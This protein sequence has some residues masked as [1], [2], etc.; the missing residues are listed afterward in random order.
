MENKEF[1]KK[2]DFNLWGNRYSNF[3]ENKHG[4]LLEDGT[5]FM[6]YYGS[7]VFYDVL[8][9]QPSF[10]TTHYEY[11]K[12]SCELKYYGKYLGIYNGRSDVKIGIWRYYDENGIL[13]KEVDEDKKFG[14]FSYN[15]VLEFLNKQ[16][17]LTTFLQEKRILNLRTGENAENIWYEFNEKTRL[18]TI[19]AFNDIAPDQWQRGWRYIINTDTG[20]LIKKERISDDSYY[21]DPVLEKIKDEDA[22]LKKAE[23]EKGIGTSLKDIGHITEEKNIYQVYKGKAYSDRA[24]LQSVR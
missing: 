4:Y 18:W 21:P 17:E 9:S 19:Q 16:K 5:E 22:A 7:V 3:K 13:T 15:E 20:K 23:Q 12:E 11:Y 2:F 14:K 6:P 24:D 1:F 10:Y 8:L